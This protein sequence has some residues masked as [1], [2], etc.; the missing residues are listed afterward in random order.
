MGVEGEG[1]V[2][3]L[4]EVFC[5]FFF[6]VYFLLDDCLVVFFVEEED[7]VIELVVCLEGNGVDFGY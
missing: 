3:E 4:V 2:V 7:V 1:F 6:F 5:Y